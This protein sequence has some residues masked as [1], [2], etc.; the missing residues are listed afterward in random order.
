VGLSE[1]GNLEGEPAAIEEGKPSGRTVLLVE[2]ESGIRLALVRAL[3]REG[4]DAI[5]A[6]NGAEAM[7]LLSDRTDIDLI[8]TDLTMPEMTGE[9]LAHRVEAERPGLPVV[10]MSGYSPS[11][12]ESASGVRGGHHFLQKPFAIELFLRTVADALAGVPA[13]ER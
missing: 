2:D 12:V 3:S 1:R 13:G 10:L 9:Q 6:A 8:V 5:A 7:R 4:Y 11:L